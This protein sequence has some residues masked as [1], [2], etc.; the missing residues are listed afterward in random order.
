[1][2]LDIEGLQQHLAGEGI[3]NRLEVLHRV[4]NADGLNDADTVFLK[5]IPAV[6]AS[7]ASTVMMTAA[8]PS[9]P[10]SPTP[11]PKF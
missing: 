9:S 2:R 4:A 1:M 5:T 3:L 6:F 8:V 10:S 11:M 7:S